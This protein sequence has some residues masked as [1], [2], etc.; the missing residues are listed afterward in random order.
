MTV[1]LNLAISDLRE[2]VSALSNIPVA[3]V[4]LLLGFPPKAIQQSD[5]LVGDTGLKSGDTIIAEAD[6]SNTAPAAQSVKVETESNTLRHITEQETGNEVPLILRKI[7][8]AD[9]SCLF[10]SMGF[11]MGGNLQFGW[12]IVIFYYFKTSSTVSITY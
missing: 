11:V 7:V 5:G 9:N 2:Q 1:P 10:T 4:K 12:I 8:P 6:S 3:S